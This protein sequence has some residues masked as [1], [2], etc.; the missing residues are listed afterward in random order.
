MN[1][2]VF[3]DNWI[4]FIID[5]GMMDDNLKTRYDSRRVKI[6]VYNIKNGMDYFEKYPV[7]D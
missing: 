6:S 7:F 5:R 4:F 2:P 3:P 1:Y